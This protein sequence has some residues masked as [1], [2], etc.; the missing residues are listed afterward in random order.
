MFKLRMFHVIALCVA[1]ALA[2]I[3]LNGMMAS[4][5]T[6]QLST[7][8][9]LVNLSTTS[10]ATVHVDY[11]LETGATWVAPAASTDFTIAMNGG[12]KIIRQYVDAMTPAT[13]RGSAI[14]SSDQPLG[15]V[16]QILARGQ[17]PTSSGAYSGFTKAD[18]K[19]YVP[20]VSRRGTSG[21]G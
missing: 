19:F 18:S 8:F 9:T 3:P 15:A 11:K 12:Q 14:V 17:N 20:L 7:N 4:S 10:N 13:G 6:K 5:T 16:V 2:V 1:F 21:S